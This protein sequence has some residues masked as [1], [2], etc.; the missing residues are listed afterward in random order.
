MFLFLFRCNFENG[1]CEWSQSETNEY[2]WRR[3]AAVSSPSYF[4]PQRDHTTNTAQGSFIFI[5]MTG[6]KNR[7]SSVLYGPSLSPTVT[8]DCQMRFYYFM[9]GK[10]V[11]KL[12]IYYREAIGGGY[13]QL[14]SQNGPVGD[15]WERSELSLPANNKAKQLVIEAT[16]ADN[17]NDSGIIAIDDVSFTTS[18]TAYSGTLPTIVTTTTG[19][20]CGDNGFQCYDGSCVPNSKVCDFSQDCSNNEDEANCGTCN[21]ENGQ[22]GW[23]VFLVFCF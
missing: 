3:T 16:S 4:Y 19:K 14:W 23:Y 20:P 15:R 1:L 21:F 12:S 5:E 9:N 17:T 10:S 7:S 11:G 22:C 13:T 6:K 2:N 8:S 18:C